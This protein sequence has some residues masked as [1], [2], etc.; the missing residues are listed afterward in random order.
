M[1]GLRVQ[2]PQG[3][4][5]TDLELELT[6]QL[7]VATEAKEHA[8]RI[9]TQA[10]SELGRCFLKFQHTCVAY[11]DLKQVLQKQDGPTFPC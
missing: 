4:L 5:M 1:R 7:K 11:N 10:T 9:A 3:S 2:I 8:E 6:R